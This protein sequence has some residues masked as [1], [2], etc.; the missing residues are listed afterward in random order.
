MS[1]AKAKVTKLGKNWTPT[2]NEILNHTELSFG[3]K[4]LW[5]YVW[6]KPKGWQYSVAGAAAQTKD[7]NY[8]ITLYAKE[9]E[10]AGYLKRIQS[11]NKKGVFGGAEWIISPKPDLRNTDNGE[12]DE[13]KADERIPVNGSAD[14]GELHTSNTISS[15]TIESKTIQDNTIEE[16]I[17][18]ALTFFKENIAS[19]L[20]I[21]TESHRKLVKTLLKQ[22]NLQ[23][24]KDVSLLKKSEWQDSEKMRRN[25]KP[26]TI[27]RLSNFDN[28]MI[29]VR[30]RRSKGESME[31]NNKLNDESKNS[32]EDDYK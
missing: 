8:K 31:A 1:E 24:I 17:D 7:T 12:T 14:D 15:K 21:K 25:L 13:R 26:K 2:P 9:L 32:W 16:K 3:A 20:K 27:F 29:D 5:A 19:G 30:E 23:D 4:G 18:A 28:Y 11:K 22:Y 6:S 10:Q